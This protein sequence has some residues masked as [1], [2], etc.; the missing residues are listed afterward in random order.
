MTCPRYYHYRCQQSLSSPYILSLSLLTLYIHLILLHAHFQ[1]VYLSIFII[2]CSHWMSVLL[3]IDC[4][5][6]QHAHAFLIYTIH[7]IS[8]NDPNSSAGKPL[9]HERMYLVLSNMDTPTV[10]VGVHIYIYVF[11]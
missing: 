8:R 4:Q 9:K 10:F 7:G 5:S 11:I 1:Y 3:R 2:D 6:E